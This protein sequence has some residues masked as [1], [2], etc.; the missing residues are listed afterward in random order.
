VFTVLLDTSKNLANAVGPPK[1]ETISET[2][3]MHSCSFQ[4]EYSSSDFNLRSPNP[5]R[6]LQNLG[7]TERTSPPR[8]LQQI[9]R[10]AFRLRIAYI[11]EK[12]ELS[13]KDF[14]E[15]IGISKSNYS[16]VESGNRMLTVDQIYNVFVIYGIPMEYLIA[17]QETNL[18]DRFRH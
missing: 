9:D 1:L 6:H 13:K 2:V 10:D 11:R 4:I 7:M 3:F 16:Q 5:L 18:P 8:K 14:A 17:G 15:S 12:T